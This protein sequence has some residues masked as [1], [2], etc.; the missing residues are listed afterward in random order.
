M[1]PVPVSEGALHTLAPEVLQHTAR[2]THYFAE[3]LRTARRMLKLMHPTLV[4][5]QLQMAPIDKHEGADLA[6]LRQWLKAGHDVGVLSESGTRAGGDIQV[7]LSG[8]TKITGTAAEPSTFYIK[9]KEGA[10]VR[11]V[12][13]EVERACLIEAAALPFAGYEPPAGIDRQGAIAARGAAVRRTFDREKNQVR[14]AVL[15]E[16]PWTSFGV[17]RCVTELTEELLNRAIEE[18]TK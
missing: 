2:I 16:R 17:Q 4:I 14:D 3:D 13:Q 15:G 8:L 7:N 9:G 12:Q 11:T 10:D 6:L 5:D 1:I 18:A